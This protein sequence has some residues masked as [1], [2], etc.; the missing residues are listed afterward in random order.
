MGI[1]R[2]IQ[3]NS[4]NPSSASA[5]FSNEY[6]Q[7]ILPRLQQ[8]INTAFKYAENGNISL[9]DPHLDTIAEIVIEYPQFKSFVKYNKTMQFPINTY[10]D[11]QNGGLPIIEQS[12]Q[13]NTDN[14]NEQH[15]MLQSE[16]SDT[17]SMILSMNESELRKL[18][19]TKN[20]SSEMI[21]FENQLDYI[22]HVCVI[23]RCEKLYFRAIRHSQ[24]GNVAECAQILAELWEYV[25]CYEMP[26]IIKNDNGQMHKMQE[27]D[28]LIIM[29]LCHRNYAQYLIDSAKNIGDKVDRNGINKMMINDMNKK[30]LNM[31]WKNLENARIYAEKYNVLNDIKDELKTAWQLKQTQFEAV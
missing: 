12:N 2:R 15:I 29:K 9:L 3:Q 4:L 17:A 23:R 21:E 8:A 19:E 11:A 31:V 27:D 24:K 16:Y 5:Y 1:N 26:I 7:S 20:E 25:C 30:L 13:Q 28:L 6:N 18:D 22:R 10:F 14:D